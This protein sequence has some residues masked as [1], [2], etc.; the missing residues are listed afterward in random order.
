L[1]LKLSTHFST[2][3]IHS[4]ATNQTVSVQILGLGGPVSRV[5][6]FADLQNPNTLLHLLDENFAGGIW[7]DFDLPTLP[8]VPATS[9]AR[10]IPW[11]AR[12][13]RLMIGRESVSAYRL[14]TRI[15]DHPIIIHVST[16]GEV[17]H[18][19]MPG[20]ITAM[21]DEWSKP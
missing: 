18:V 20:G 11:E 15:L 16:L 5:L 10:A 13:D 19:E 21:L 3:E 6:T 17:L 8:S 4:L 2:V 9:L 1:R 14:E 12:R 7:S